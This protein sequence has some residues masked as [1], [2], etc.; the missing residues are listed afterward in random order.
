MFEERGNLLGQRPA[1]NK[2]RLGDSQFAQMDR[3]SENGNSKVIHIGLNERRN[4]IHAVTVCIRLDHR[5]H[6]C[7]GNVRADRFYI[8]S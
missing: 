1:C 4:T 7:R 8:F 6:F 3:F 2:D 5:H